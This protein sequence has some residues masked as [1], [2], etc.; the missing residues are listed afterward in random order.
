MS[1]GVALLAS[2]IPSWRVKFSPPKLNGNFGLEQHNNA[3]G[4]GE[5]QVSK[6][7]AKAE[8]VA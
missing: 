7:F 8:I 2:L 4:G 1:F 6:R 3:H 5:G